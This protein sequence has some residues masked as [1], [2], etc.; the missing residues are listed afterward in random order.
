M[1]HP[2]VKLVNSEH[3]SDSVNSAFSLR[4][5]PVNERQKNLRKQHVN[6]EK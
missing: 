2:P 4:K 3:K 1:S 6:R 5:Q